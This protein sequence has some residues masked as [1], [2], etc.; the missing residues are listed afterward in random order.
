[1]ISFTTQC[2]DE[3]RNLY[4]TP[5]LFQKYH[6]P[7]KSASIKPYLTFT[8]GNF[9]FQN[10]FF[11]MQEQNKSDPSWFLG[12]CCLLPAALHCL[13]LLL[14]LQKPFLIHHTHL[15]E[16]HH[17][18]LLAP[19]HP[20]HLHHVITLLAFKK[21][22]SLNEKK[23]VS[24]PP[25]PSSSTTLPYKWC[26]FSR[27]PLQQTKNSR[28]KMETKNPHRASRSCLPLPHPNCQS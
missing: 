14:Q 6:V 1:M 18:C 9:L 24:S 10:S 27:G 13:Q 17:H 25:T 8:N 3:V 15:Q 4:H 5:L 7:L 21:N 12:S 28:L 2:Q 26:W 22:D 19:C 20:C 16:R 11:K 23:R